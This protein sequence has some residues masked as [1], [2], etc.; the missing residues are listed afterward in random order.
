V[1]EDIVYLSVNRGGVLFFERF[2]FHG[3]MV[4]EHFDS[5][6][7]YDNP[8]SGVLTGLDHLDGET[9]GVWADDQDRGEFT[10]SAGSIDVSATYADVTVGLRYTG[11]YKSNK[12]S[13]YLATPSGVT[14]VIGMLKRVVNL[15][16]TME[17]YWPGSVRLGPTFDLLEDM[18]EIEWGAPVD[19]TVLITEYDEHPFE[20]NGND[21]IDPRICFEVTGPARILA[22]SYG[23]LTENEVKD[24]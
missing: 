8:G 5:A 11:R 17:D 19:P 18:P 13:Q 22:M 16:L 15:G 20:F 23:V 1:K 7:I 9:V 10:V 14:R 24:T 4:T 12:I 21:D 6:V 2:S 3:D